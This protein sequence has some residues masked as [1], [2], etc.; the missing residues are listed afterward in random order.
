[1]TDIR[2]QTLVSSAERAGDA[3]MVMAL[4]LPGSW[5]NDGANSREAWLRERQCAGVE[6]RSDDPRLSLAM[7]AQV[8]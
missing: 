5:R 3:G 4:Q 1:M 7:P 6:R 8:R 2:E